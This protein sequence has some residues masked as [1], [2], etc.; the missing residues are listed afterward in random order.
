MEDEF[1]DPNN[2]QMISDA[3]GWGQPLRPRIEG[4]RKK[5]EQMNGQSE[6][7]RQQCKVTDTWERLL[8]TLL[9]KTA[10]TEKEAKSAKRR[11]GYGHIRHPPRSVTTG[12]NCLKVIRMNSHNKDPI[13]CCL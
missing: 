8:S 1:E 2:L 11:N 7:G 13:L 3:A 6:G 4:R 5:G 12:K 10:K 9:L